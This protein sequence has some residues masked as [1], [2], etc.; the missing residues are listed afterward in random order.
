MT[1][2]LSIID[3]IVEVVVAQQSYAGT[4]PLTEWA[5]LEEIIESV[6]MMQEAM[7]KESGITVKKTFRAH[8]N[9]SVQRN[10]LIHVLINLIANARDAM[11]SNVELPENILEISTSIEKGV[12]IIQVRDNGIG[13]DSDHLIKIFNFGFTLKEGGHGFGLHSCANYMSEMKGSIE[14]RSDGHSKGSTFTLRFHS[15]GRY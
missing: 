1:R 15:T 6:L 4:I 2:L 5:R 12:P 13:I 3:A 7:I 14:A 10:K 8:V 9:V 11:L